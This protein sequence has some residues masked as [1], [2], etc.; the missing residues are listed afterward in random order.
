MKSATWK[1]GTCLSLAIGLL[2]L[3]GIC[4]SAGPALA[5]FDCPL[6]AGV[7]P[8]AAPPVT[9]QQVEDGSASLTDF[10]LAVRDVFVSESQG[11]TTS[12]ITTLAQLAYVGCLFRQEGGRGVPVPPTS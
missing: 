10:A 4:S 5:Q 8:P 7:T 6:P 9:A 12:N 2:V 11:M 3:A 1:T